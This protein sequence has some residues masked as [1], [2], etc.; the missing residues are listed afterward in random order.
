[1]LVPPTFCVLD[2]LPL[3]RALLPLALDHRVGTLAERF[4]CAR[5]GAHRGRRRCGNARGHCRGPG[6][7]ATQQRDWRCGPTS[8]AVLAIHERGASPPPDPALAT[9]IIARFGA[10]ITPLLPERPSL[11]PVAPN[12]TAVDRAFAQAEQLG[13]TRR[14][15]QIELA[16]LAAST[17]ATGGYATIEAGTARAK[18]WVPAPRGAARCATGQPVAVSHS[19]VCCKHSW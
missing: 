9:D 8:C 3:A 13:H 11:A 5:P 16:H 18:V 1:M 17:F 12:L 2:T 4:G 7:G 15:P 6:A 14:E 19:H 10:N